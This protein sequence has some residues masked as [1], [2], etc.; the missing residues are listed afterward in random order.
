MNNSI[1]LYDNTC[2]LCNSTV[3]FLKKANTVGKIRFIPVN[4]SKGEDYIRAY[5]IKNNDKNS[6]IHI[7]EDKYY[8]K[9][10]AVLSVLRIYKNYKILQTVLWLVPKYFRD[11]L[12]DFIAKNRYIWFGKTKYH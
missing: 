5:H 3:H 1:V 4:S 9:S 12:Y 2:R 6:V 11:L 7:R 10:E 8:T